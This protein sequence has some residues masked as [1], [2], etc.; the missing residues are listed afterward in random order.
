MDLFENAQKNMP[1]ALPVDSRD[2][3]IKRKE[4]VRILK[5]LADGFHPLTGEELPDES[6]YQSAKVLRALIAGIEALEA[7]PNQ[8]NKSKPG[9]KSAGKPWD[10][11]E[12]Q[13]L[14]MDWE[15][16]STIK[17]LAANHQ[18]TEGAIRSRLIRLG[19]IQ[20]PGGGD[21]A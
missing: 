9:L 20:P 14:L 17:D 8:A 13:T 16:G 2:P 1:D 18:R 21:T 11:E 10:K 12:D 4:S 15:S 5:A 3:E 7:A 6:C 19:A